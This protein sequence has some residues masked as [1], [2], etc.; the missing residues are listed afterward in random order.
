[1]APADLPLVA[2]WLVRPHVARWFLA[3][4]SLEHEVDELRR[5]VAG[6]D[7]TRALMVEED[8]RPI[9]WCQWYGVDDFPA[10]AEGVGA[11]PG[12]VGIDY[13]IGEPD[14]TGAGVGTALVAGVVA[15]VGEARPG[16]GVVADPEA[17]NTASRRVL[18]KNGFALVSV[19]PVAS[20]TTDAPMAVYRRP[21]GP[22]PRPR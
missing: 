6:E 4:S 21:P 15:L 10:H 8:G 19:G 14:R 17:A 7:P 2:A 22:A 13:A 5:C 20:E 3:A 1:M 18:E 16:A 9:G 12:D 11:A